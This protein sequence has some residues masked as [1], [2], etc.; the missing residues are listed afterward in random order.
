MPTPNAYAFLGSYGDTQY[1]RV[2]LAPTTA[3]QALQSWFS[4]SSWEKG[5][6]RNVYF[7]TRVAITVGNVTRI[8]STEFDEDFLLSQLLQLD[9]PIEVYRS[10]MCQSYELDDDGYWNQLDYDSFEESCVIIPMAVENPELL[11]AKTEI[12]I[13]SCTQKPSEFGYIYELP[14]N[15]RV[16]EKSDHALEG[17]YRD[18]DLTW[19][20]G[21]DSYTIVTKKDFHRH[22]KE[23]RLQSDGY[24]NSLFSLSGAQKNQSRVSLSLYS[25]I[26]E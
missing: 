4:A 24:D 9:Q 12:Y 25:V 18:F 20:W 3:C 16:Y 6:Y 11:R 22:W 15:I 23:Q 17:I 8:A 5:N 26:T 2:I 1:P 10:G 21:G 7:V 13:V 19:I 14:S